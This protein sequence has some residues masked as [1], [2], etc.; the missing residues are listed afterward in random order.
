MNQK[1]ISFAY[2]ALQGIYWMSHGVVYSFAAVFLLD[3]HFTDS[4]VGAIIA[5]SCIF[6]ALFQPLMAAAADRGEMF[7]LRSLFTMLCV[8]AMIPAM[9]LFFFRKTSAFS[10]FC[11][12]LFL[13]LHLSIQPLLSALGMQL[14]NN[15]YPLNFGVARGIGSMS[16]AALTFFLGAI[17][18][19]FT[20]SCLPLLA[21]VLYVCLILLLCFFPNTR[22]R[23]ARTV[24]SVG[25]MAVLQKHKKFSLFILGILLIF[26]SHSAINTYAIQ[27]LRPMGK[28]NE[29]LGQLMAY[30]AVLEFLVM[31]SFSRIMKGRDC[32]NVLKFTAVF[33]VLKGVLVAMAPNLPLLYGAFLTQLFSFALFTPASVYYADKILE[34]GDSVKG[35]ALITVA[36]TAGNIL[37]SF[38]CGFF[39]DLWGIT[40]AIWVTTAFTAIGMV[41]FFCGVEKVGKWEEKR[42]S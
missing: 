39:I 21:C 40:A 29:E 12:V 31:L 24:S 22:R 26:I 25:T 1:T 16:Y 19:R 17:T 41:F 2:A 13:L 9:L 18:L 10:A 7:S 23:G 5:L 36:I 30:T 37:G 8:V 35:Q 42:L 4:Q 38:F 33:F 34:E 27:I 6:S 32:G 3:R 11:Y 20:T 14:I 15:G 28:G